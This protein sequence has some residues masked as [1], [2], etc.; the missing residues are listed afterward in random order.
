MDDFRKRQKMEAMEWMMLM[1]VREDVLRAFTDGALMLCEN[2]LYR[3][4]SE[5]EMEDVRQFE[6][7]HDSVVYLS[8]RMETNFGTLDALLFVSKYEE[9]WELSREDAQCGYALSYCINRNY[10]ECSE[11]GSIAFRVTVDGGI[12]R[13]G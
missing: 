3:P 10:P 7:D 8:V 2:G 6:Q 12:I 1:G 5:S 11:M 9:D 4:L 13:V